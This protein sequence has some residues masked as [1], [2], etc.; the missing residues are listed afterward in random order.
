METSPWNMFSIIVEKDPELSAIDKVEG[1]AVESID[2]SAPYEV[3]SLQG[4]RLA[5]SLDQLPAG[6]Y[7]VRQGSHTAKIAIQ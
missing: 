6:L 4:I 5:A 2:Y 3:Y 1:E 7:V